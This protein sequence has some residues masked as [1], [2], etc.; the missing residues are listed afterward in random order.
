MV[1]EREGTGTIAAEHIAQMPENLRP[2]LV[3]CHSY[4]PHGAQR[5]MNVFRAASIRCLKIP[6]G[7]TEYFQLLAR[8]SV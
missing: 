7:Q 3:V 2:R 5:M 8:R 6:F 4:N 1:E